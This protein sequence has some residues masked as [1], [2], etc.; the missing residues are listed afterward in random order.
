MAENEAGFYLYTD[1]RAYLKAFYDRQR[2]CDPKFSHRFYKRKLDRSSS[3]YFSN[4]LSG[5]K[6]LKGKIIEDIIKKILGIDPKKNPADAEYFRILCLFTQAAEDSRKA[7][8]QDER[9]A[10]EAELRLFKE[11]LEA[12]NKLPTKIV[13]ETDGEFFSSWHHSAILALLDTMDYKGNPRDLAVKLYPGLNLKQV[14][15]SIRLLERLKLIRLDE[16]GCWKPVSRILW[17]GERDGKAAPF[18]RRYRLECLKVATRIFSDNPP[19]E[20][21]FL[22]ETFS[23]STLALEKIKAKLS[24]FRNEVVSIINTD[25]GLV[26]HVYQL[27]VQLLPHSRTVPS[28]VELAK[29]S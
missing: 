1:A 19:M 29:Q 15:E 28:K 5:R 16:R 3:S 26:Q 23:L 9:D 24:R 12:L 22:T 27:N 4:I 20:K 13:D 25:G 2:E 14:R 18:I 10:R 17:A 21:R 11:K 8:S 6:R 7:K